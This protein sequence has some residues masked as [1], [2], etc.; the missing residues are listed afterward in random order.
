MEDANYFEKLV[1]RG[2]KLSI[3]LAFP[4]RTLPL[5]KQKIEKRM[6]FLM[7]IFQIL[8]EDKLV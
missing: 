2:Q 7:E 4:K 3:Y 8:N 5:G 6:F 1:N